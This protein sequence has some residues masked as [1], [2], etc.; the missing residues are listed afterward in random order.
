L[1]VGRGSVR[2]DVK[3]GAKELL[4]LNRWQASNLWIKKE[5]EGR[6]GERWRGEYY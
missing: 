1:D 4:T 5:R 3:D 2:G 6:E